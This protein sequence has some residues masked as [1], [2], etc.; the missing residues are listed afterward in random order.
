M[1]KK[2]EV[3]LQTSGSIEKYPVAKTPI[4]L[5][6]EKLRAIGFDN[7]RI[8]ARLMINVEKINDYK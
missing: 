2:K 4:Q 3:K 7:N 5:E 8:A 1:A 6:I